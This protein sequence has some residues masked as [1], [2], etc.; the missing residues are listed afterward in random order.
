MRPVF[1]LVILA[2][3]VVNSDPRRFY[4]AQRVLSFAPVT[5]MMLETYHRR[6]Q[7]AVVSG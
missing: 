4:Y 3:F 7:G 5:E 1:H 2:C 6:G